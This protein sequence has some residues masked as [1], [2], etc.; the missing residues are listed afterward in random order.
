MAD[1]KTHITT[2]TVVGIGY[3]AAGYFLG[4]PPDT[5][6]LAAGMCSVS[7]ILPDL[8]SGSGIPL[9]ETIAFSA[10]IIPMFMIHRFSEFGL[11]HE[12]MVLAA[13]L[14]YVAVRFGVGEIFKRYTVHRGMWHSLPAAA[15]V[16]LLAFL[17]C[18]DENIDA[19][20]YKA[21]AALLGFMVHL[22]LDELWSIEMRG[23]RMRLKKSSGT[24]IKFF[25]K[26]VWGNVSVYGKLILVAAIAFG[27]P[28]VMKNIREM[29]LDTE[30]GQQQMV[31]RIWEQGQ[32]LL[33]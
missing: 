28:I 32:N 20:W 15:T 19:R 16:C 4:V 26:S 13:G 7:G 23:G 24:A 9:R 11:S 12:S 5:A 33:R 21:S 29:H 17:A 22:I 8:D 1:F 10:A 2:S 14:I 31:E 3:G 25:G 18:T 6:M 27:D 30:E